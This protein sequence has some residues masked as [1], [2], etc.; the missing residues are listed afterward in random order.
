MFFA[1]IKQINRPAR[2]VKK[3]K[4]LEIKA[5]MDFQHLDALRDQ[6]GD[7]EQEMSHQVLIY[8]D[9]VVN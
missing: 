2:D 9:V 7:Q 8:C 5:W 3:L 1:R 4:R 6:E